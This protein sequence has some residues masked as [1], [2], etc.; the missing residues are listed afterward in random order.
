M[1]LLQNTAS[2]ER[3][4]DVHP[5][6]QCGIFLSF[7][8]QMVVTTDNDKAPAKFLN[9][10]HNIRRLKVTRFTTIDV[11]NL[12]GILDDTEKIDRKVMWLSGRG[13]REDE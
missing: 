1:E 5:K 10:I 8:A 6:H 13:S 3:C 7:V 4:S 11:E 9:T 12:G 2:G